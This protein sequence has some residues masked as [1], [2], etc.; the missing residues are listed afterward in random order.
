VCVCVCVCVR[1]NMW[2]SVLSFYYVGTRDRTL[3]IELGGKCLY[4]LS[5]L[6]GLCPSLLNVVSLVTLPLLLP[7][8]Q[9]V[10]T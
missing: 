8:S 9:T 6:A 10:F 3:V 2:Q 4:I 1:D 5:H 7:S